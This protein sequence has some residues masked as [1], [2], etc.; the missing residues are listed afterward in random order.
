MSENVSFSPRKRKFI[1][2]ES[3]P[4]RQRVPPSIVEFAESIGV[5]DRTVYRWKR[6]PEIREAISCRITELLG[7]EL[8]DIWHAVVHEAKA[9]SY[10]HAKLVLEKLDEYHETVVHK[11]SGTINVIEAALDRAYEDR[12]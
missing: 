6:E 5:C 10:Q 2:W 8:A 1:E 7:D 9:G 11:H 12:D 3:H 4:K